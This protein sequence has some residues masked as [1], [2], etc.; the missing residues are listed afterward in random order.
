MELIKNMEISGWFKI[1]GVKVGDN[2][3]MLKLPE[4]KILAE[5]LLALLFL[6]TLWILGKRKSEISSVTSTI[7]QRR[8]LCAEMVP[9][10]VSITPRDTVKEPT[11]L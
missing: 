5:L 2:K 7:S 4:V 3:A 9:Q 1:L 8:E 10:Q 11:K 6:L